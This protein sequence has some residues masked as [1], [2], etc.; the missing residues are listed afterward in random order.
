MSAP[1]G[2]VHVMPDYGPEHIESKDCWCEP[3]LIADETPH[4]GS[5]CYLHKELQ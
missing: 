3:E 1:D 4:G 2:N 5:K